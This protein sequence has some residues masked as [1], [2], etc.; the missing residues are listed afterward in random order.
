MIR[1]VYPSQARGTVSAPPSKSAAHR[2][3]IGAALARGES[4]VACLALSRDIEATAAGL[5]ALGA[6]IKLQNGVA[7]VTGI[8]FTGPAP[9]HILPCGESGSTLR[10]LLPLCLL[11][12]EETT[13]TG[14]ERLFARGLSVYEAI[15]RDRDILFRQERDRV[16]VRGRLTPGI[17]RLPGNVS[18]QFITGLLYAL[19][20]LSGDSEIHLTTGLQSAPYL[21]M[22]LSALSAFGVGVTRPAPDRFLI[23][24]GQRFSPR[25]VTVEG[26]W[27]NAAFLLA[28]NGLGGE[29][30]VTGLDENSPQG[31]KVCRGYLEAI[32]NG[33]PTLDVSDCPDLAPVLMACAAL[34]HGA[35]L[36]G[37]ARLKIKESDRGAV[38]AEELRKCGAQVTVEEDEITVAP[39]A[40]HAPAAALCGHNDHR[41]VMA[42][43]VL[44]SV[45]GGEVTDAGAVAKSWPD[46]FETLDSIGVKTLETDER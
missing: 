33:A 27:S 1:R 6:G 34:H 44:L 24:G 20:L 41:V 9:A 38:M 7:A 21:D 32:R 31:D 42:L 35:V 18:S 29:L 3:L 10:F 13:L 46:F 17:Y 5:A 40:L 16:T 8:D 2:L 30:T 43:T 26:D 39:G 23:P 19:P 14:T 37:T 12:E 25:S 15:C 4:E 22:T 36:T 45:L 11:R 28:L